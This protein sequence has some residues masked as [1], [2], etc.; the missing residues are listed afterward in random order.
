MLTGKLCMHVLRLALI[1]LDSTLLESAKMFRNQHDMKQ[2]D[3]LRQAVE[4]R[5]DLFMD[6]MAK[7]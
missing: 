2:A 5:K 7:S 6:I 1:A 4:L 3:S